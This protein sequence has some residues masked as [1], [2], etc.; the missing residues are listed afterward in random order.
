MRKELEKKLLQHDDD[1]EMALLDTVV[2]ALDVLKSTQE[3]INSILKA[4]DSNNETLSELLAKEAPEANFEPITASLD[5]LSAKFDS[6][7]EAIGT[8]KGADL[9]K[10]EKLLS[11]IE[12]NNPQVTNLLTELIAEVKKKRRV[13]LR[14]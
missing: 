11:D 6:I 2:D 14:Y 12:K 10:V 3:G 5:Q 8:I 9:S 13:H 4:S 7:K 1:K